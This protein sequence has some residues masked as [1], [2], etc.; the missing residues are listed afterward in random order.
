MPVVDSV[1][2][3]LF[4]SLKRDFGDVQPEGQGAL[5]FQMGNPVVQDP[6]LLLPA[7]NGGRPGPQRR[8]GQFS[9]VQ[10]IR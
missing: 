10:L 2:Q 9:P 7:G 3:I 5:V 4:P 1:D 8:G 6:A